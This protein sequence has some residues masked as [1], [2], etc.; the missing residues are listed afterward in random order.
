MDT[1][2]SFTLNRFINPQPHKRNGEFM[3]TT[4]LLASAL[5][6]VFA[7]GASATTVSFPDFS[8]TAGLTLNGNVTTETTADGNVLRL[9]PALSAQSGSAFSTTTINAT[10]FSSFFKFRITSPGGLTFDGNPTTGADGLV[11][12]VQNISSNIG[13]VGAG[14]G[15]GGIGQSI[16]V[17]W[18]TWHNTANNDPDSN[19]LGID[20]NGNVNHGAGSPNTVSIPTRFDDENIWYSWVDYNGTTLE[21]RTNQTGIR[22]NNPTLSQNLDIA[23]ILGSNSAYVGFTS[24]T[25]SAWGNHDILSWE[26][27]DSYNPISTV[28]EPSVVGL[29]GSALAGFLGLRH[30][31]RKLERASGMMTTNV[32]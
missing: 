14:I 16:G 18:D 9:T 27:R 22:P 31:A 13:S 19:H 17:E 6:L 24:A 30:R 4:A 7:T 28:P 15:Y 2:L 32:G 23:S 29:F 20:I 11:F 1:P 26:Y 5:T 8:S 21:V 3:N 12:V 25:G 10:N